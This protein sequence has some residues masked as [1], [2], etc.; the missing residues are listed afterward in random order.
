[1]ACEVGN[2]ST[3]N[4]D[5]DENDASVE[6]LD[7]D[8]DGFQTCAGDCNDNALGVY[9]GANEIPNDGID[10]NCSGSDST[11]TPEDLDGDGFTS[12]DGDC[13]DNNQYLPWGSRNL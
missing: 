8:G 3:T 9:P 2:Y 13:N 12:D 7:S 11:P 1:M 10:Q 4:T 6:S 5:C